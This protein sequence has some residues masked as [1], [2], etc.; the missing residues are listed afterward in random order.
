[1]KPGDIYWVEL[2]TDTSGS[3]MRRPGLVIQ[4]DEHAATSPVVLVVPLT[5][6]SAVA[7]LPGTLVIEPTPE[8]GLLQP[9]VALVFQLSA[10][11]RGRVKE[12]IGGIRPDTI[13][14]VRKTLDRL[15]GRS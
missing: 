10:V 3:P 11:E 1:M 9:S 6:V 5:T 4:D 15:M 12:R 13:N 14:V 8:N 2:P 7:R